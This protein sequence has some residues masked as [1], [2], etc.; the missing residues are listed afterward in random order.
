MAAKSRPRAKV[1][2]ADGKQKLIRFVVKQQF[3]V[4]GEKPTDRKDTV[5]LVT[6]KLIIKAL[7]ELSPLPFTKCYFKKVLLA[8]HA[9]KKHKNAEEWTLKDEKAESW[10]EHIARRLVLIRK[11]VQ[12]GVK[13]QPQW[14]RMLNL[15]GDDEE[16]ENEDEDENEDEAD[17]AAESED[18]EEKRKRPTKRA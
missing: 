1:T 4:Y 12:T 9:E 5:G 7:A 3:I 16:A 14:Y 6:N 18:E 11:H 15:G 13:T 2:V 8:I 17:E 10:A